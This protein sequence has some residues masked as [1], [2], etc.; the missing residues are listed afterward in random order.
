MI[1]SRIAILLAVLL[2]GLASAG[3]A[4]AQEG[5]EPVGTV[6]IFDSAALGDAA[7]ITL[8]NVTPPAAGRAYEGWLVSDDGSVKLSTG[9]MTIAADG[10]AS[11]GYVSPTGENLIDTYN[12]F[13]IT[14]EPVP[15]ADPAPS[16]II[17]YSHQI[18]LSAMVH[19][20]H[21]LTNWPPGADVGILTNLQTQLAAAVLHAELAQASTDLE[22]LQ[23]HIHHVLNIIEGADGANYDGSFGDPGDGLG[24]LLH[25]GDRK[26]ATF[27]AGEA[28]DDLRITTHAALV[29]VNGKN[30]EDRA[31]AAR[32]Q[33]LLVLT[34]GSLLNAQ[35]QTIPV[36]GFLKAALN[37]VDNDGDGTIESIA[38]EGG[39]KQ[40]YVEAQR[41][42]AY[43]LVAGDVTTGGG[44]PGPTLGL[45]SV[46]DTSVRTL[47]WASLIAALALLGAGAM[48]LAKGRRS[49]IDA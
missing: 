35:I 3:V 14:D 41:M 26:H 43:D 48:V 8:T 32:D 7:L 38:E 22:T 6:I 18:P 11:H 34:V 37:G 12:K 9:V 36:V 42:A 46:G 1:R 30:A 10:T 17:V 45:P 44:L 4:L 2:L 20:R 27:A 5:A 47:V 24:V 19:I 31:I 39:A 28:P 29:D 23:L 49:R 25:A 40:A 33:A 21:L 15:D 16:G 13:L